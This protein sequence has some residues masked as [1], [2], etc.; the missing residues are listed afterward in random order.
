MPLL[1]TVYYLFAQPLGIFNWHI[2]IALSFGW[3]GDISLMVHHE[4]KGNKD[5]T[6]NIKPMMLGL[7]F[8]LCGHITYFTL[9]IKSSISLS[10][11]NALFILIYIAYIGYGIMVYTYLGSHGLL[12]PEVPEKALSK[13]SVLI[14]RSGIILY[15]LGITLMSYSSLLRLI[16]LQSG[17]TIFTFIGSLVF[18]SS[19]S[20]LSM[21]MLG[22]KESMSEQY[23][24]G[25][26]I[27][28]QVLIVIGY[29]V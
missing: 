15:M 12:H 11:E 13:K 16:N 6:T 2:I 21:K 14:L 18:M 1:A 10:E 22:Q 3:L 8:F 5:S 17:A 9:F 4:S 25:S 7:A 24:M 23:I 19:D 20:V 27:V 29:I 26:Y 28:A